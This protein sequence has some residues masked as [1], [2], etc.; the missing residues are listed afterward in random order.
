MPS[1]Y[2]PLEI[3]SLR[4]KRSADFAIFQPFFIFI[5]LKLKCKFIQ[6]RR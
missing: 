1:R 3:F 5:L 6:Q 4:E 2:A